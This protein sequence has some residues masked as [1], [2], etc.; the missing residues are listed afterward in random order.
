MTRR[1]A[2]AIATLTLAVMITAPLAANA[3]CMSDAEAA[4]L[5]AS[6]VAKKPAP[7]PEGMPDADGEYTRSKVN[8]L[9]KRQFGKPV[10]YEAGLTKP[11]G[12]EAL[13]RQRAGVGH[14]L[15]AD[16]AEERRDSRSG[17]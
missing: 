1:P 3:A 11:R 15:R 2:F 16:A 8:S 10:G 7:N 14:A 9:L 13:R 6:Y 5:V 12:A 4:A 17:I